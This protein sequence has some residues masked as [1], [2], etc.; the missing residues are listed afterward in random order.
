MPK[1]TRMPEGNNTN[2]KREVELARKSRK[3]GLTM[4]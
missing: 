3:N 1:I 4:N 2:Y